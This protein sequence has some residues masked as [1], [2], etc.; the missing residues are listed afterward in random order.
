MRNGEN[1]RAGRR[2]LSRLI[3]TALVFCLLVLP[4]SAAPGGDGSSEASPLEV[5]AEG[6]AF[7]NGTIYGIQKTWFSDVNPRKNTLY[8]S[9]VI[10]DSINGTPVRDIAFEAFTT[11]YTSDKKAKGAVTYNDN[12]GLFS[13]TSVDFSAASHLETIQK[14][15]FNGCGYL[16]GTIDLSHTRLVMIDKL[17]FQNCTGLTEVVLPETLESL[18]GPNGGSVFKGCS[19]LLSVRTANDAPGTAFSLPSG[20]KYIGADTFNGAFAQPV[21]ATIPASVI[22][23]GSQAFY[24]NQ[25]TRIVLTNPAP[26]S[27]FFSGSGSEWL[28]GQVNTRALK[29]GSGLDMVL[30]PNAEVYEA[31]YENYSGLNSEKN[32]FTFPM[33]VRFW[34]EDSSAILETQEK[35]YNFPLNY[36]QNG[37]WSQDPAYQFPQIDEEETQWFIEGNGNALKETNRLRSDP[38]QSIFDLV[39]EVTRL[40]IPANPTVVPVLDG[41]LLPADQ[42]SV[43]V[44]DERVHTF[45][46]QVA[47]PLLTPPENPEPGN[48]YVEFQYKWTDVVDGVVGPR[49]EEQEEGFGA[50]G[51]HAAILIDGPAHERT[52]GDYYLVEIEGYVWRYD[53]SNWVKDSAPYFKTKHTIIGGDN[54]GATVDRAYVYSVEVLETYTVTYTDGVDGEE[55][56]ADQVFDGLLAGADTPDFPGNPERDGYLFQGWSPAL[57]ETVTGDTVYTAQWEKEAGEE[58]P[59]EPGDPT[60]PEK[61]TDPVQPETPDNPEDSER[62]ER[63]GDVTGS[64]DPAD[65]TDEEKPTADPEKPDAQN[66]PAT[67]DAGHP[68]LWLILILASGIALMSAMLRGKRSRPI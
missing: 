8:L 50:F 9:V 56:F 33:T 34:N 51:P 58:H 29:C 57:A 62:P 10:P 26:P 40:V 47:H 2:V 4:I 63:P 7:E 44:K 38:V 25:I 66:T 14:Q 42:T 45:G 15:A 5:P 54:S 21:T 36:V 64:E 55:I 20:L 3:Q 27:A 48:L 43:T 60:D 12:L 1:I 24:S 59:A 6:L 41:V 28:S 49:S 39:P 65:T 18:G 67:G 19:G 17:A 61:P 23:I 31:Y 22:G 16:K 46:V 32:K 35:L 37:N 53:G 30:F 11:A 13:L 52:D 68:F